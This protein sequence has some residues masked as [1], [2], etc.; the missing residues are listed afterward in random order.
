MRSMHTD[1][2][3]TASALTGAAMTWHARTRAQQRAIRPAM[4][5]LLLDHGTSCPAGNGAE[6]VFLPRC[7][8]MELAAQ[9]GS[10]SCD[11]VAATYAVVSA[12]GAVITVGHRTRRLP[13]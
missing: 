1:R 9:I 13:R 6:I 12:E 4:L 3:S 11:R 7:T 2:N 8:R 5:D 10:A